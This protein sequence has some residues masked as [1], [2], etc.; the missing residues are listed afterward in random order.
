MSKS[1]FLNFVKKYPSFKKLYFFYN[2]Y[3]INFNFL[4]NVSQFQEDKF[5][6]E[7]FAKGHKDIT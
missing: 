6:L 4:K 1:K 2:I 5:I 3:I 7:N